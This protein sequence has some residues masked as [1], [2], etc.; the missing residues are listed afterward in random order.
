[1]QLIV[2]DQLK[3]GGALTTVALR[4]IEEWGTLVVQLCSYGC[5]GVAFGQ[6]FARNSI[7]R[8]NPRIF[9]CHKVVF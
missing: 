3:R 7:N 8:R 5:P 1:M 2:S 6:K 4:L 9:G